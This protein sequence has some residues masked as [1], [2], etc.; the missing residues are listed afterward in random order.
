MLYEGTTYRPPPEADSLLLQVTV[1]CA[2][3]R[4]RF[5]TMYRDVSYR[6]VPMDRIEADLRE[7]RGIFARAERIFLVNGDAFVL[8]AKKLK[9]IAARIIKVFSECRT[10]SMYASIGNIQT[11]SDQ[12][13][14]ELKEAGINDLY[15]GVESGWDKV[16]MHLNKGHTVAQAQHQLNR[17][18]QAGIKHIANLMLGVAGLGNGVENGRRTADFL[19][20]TRPDLIWVGTLGIFEG[21][22]LYKEM[23]NG[24]FVPASELEILEEEKTLINE[25]DL[26]KV[27]F[28]GV[29]PTNTVRLAGKLPDD[30]PKMIAAIDNAI[31]RY[32]KEALTT[33]FAR[34]SL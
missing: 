25:I 21:T 11:K 16:L 24:S 14:A 6:P 32:G 7:A 12:D 4:C 27:P 15:V 31:S 30:R 33:T 28:Y 10:I 23:A 19:N 5:C 2:H 34:T 20:R 26:P 22:E 1:G 3:N 29:H 13:L 8:K 17:L 18:N 9:A